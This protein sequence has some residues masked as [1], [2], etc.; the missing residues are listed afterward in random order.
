MCEELYTL[1]KALEGESTSIQFIVR[2][3][4]ELLYVGDDGEPTEI[5]QQSGWSFQD[6]FYQRMYSEF[7]DEVKQLDLLEW[8]EDMEVG[9]TVEVCEGLD[10]VRE[11]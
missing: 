7:I 4:D 2:N 8:T 10:I 5:L 6:E 3:N 1:T 9:E 11:G